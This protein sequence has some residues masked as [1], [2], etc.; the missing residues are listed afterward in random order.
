MGKPGVILA[1]SFIQLHT[2]TMHVSGFSHFLREGTCDL[3]AAV[4]RTWCPL[5]QYC[6]ERPRW[7][8]AFSIVTAT[9]I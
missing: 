9:H 6:R 8:N 2:H 1:Q 5:T 4:F 7:I 3:V